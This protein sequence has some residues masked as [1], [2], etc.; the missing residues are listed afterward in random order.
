MVRYDLPL[1]E[2]ENVF[3]FQSVR[4]KNIRY[5]AEKEKFEV[6]Y[7]CIRIR[8][9]WILEVKL[10]HVRFFTLNCLH[11]FLMVFRTKQ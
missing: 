3:R 7:V 10:L 4:M 2:T 9:L 11:D 6:L 8:N 1:K 5:I